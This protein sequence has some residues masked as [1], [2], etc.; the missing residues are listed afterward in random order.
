MVGDTDTI[1]H[2][3]LPPIV[4]VINIEKVLYEC[5]EA[6]AHASREA[7]IEIDALSHNLLAA[8][9]QVAYHTHFFLRITNPELLE[10]Q[11]QSPAI[12]QEILDF[13]VDVAK[14]IDKIAEDLR[15]SHGFI[16]PKHRDVDNSACRD[17]FNKASGKI[18]EL[19]K[20]FRTMRENLLLQVPSS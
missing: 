16:G 17:C 9:D 3:D 6:I 5:G 12:L 19:A 4:S 18:S 10:L 2:S 1:N 20:S 11:C 13:R 15:C 8:Y 14:S 7:R